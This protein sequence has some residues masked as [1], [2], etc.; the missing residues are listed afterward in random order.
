MKVDGSLK[1]LLQGVSQQPPRDRLPGQST[2]QI[3]MSADPVTG[4]TRRPPTDLV[5]PLSPSSSPR[6]WYDFETATGDKFIAQFDDGLLQVWD[7]NAVAMDVVIETDA[8]PYISDIGPYVC[9]TQE[10]KVIVS[11][12]VRKVAMKSDTRVY[13]N[14]GTGSKPQGLIQI[15]GGNYGRKYAISVDGTEVCSYTCPDGSSGNHSLYVT[16]KVIA[17]I[18]E[19]LLVNDSAGTKPAHFP[20]GPFYS[21]AGALNS[22]TDWTVSRKDDIIRIQKLTGAAFLLTVTDDAGNVTAKAMTET[23]P[24]VS[25][26]PRMAPQGYLARIATETD[27]EEDL[28]VEFVVEDQAGAVAT[29][30]GFGKPGFWQECVASGIKYKLDPA[31]MPHILEYDPNTQVFTFRQGTW[32]DRKVGTTT[33]NPD[34]SFVGYPINDVSTFMNRTVFLAGSNVI[35]SRTN[36]DDDFWM[37]SVSA[38]VDSD[39]IDISSNAV[40]TSEMI[41]AIPHNKDLVIFARKGQFTIFGRTQLTPANAAVVLTTAFE[42]SLDA[43]PAPAGRNVFF[44]VTYGRFAGIREFY[45]EGGTDINDTRPV[46]QHLKKFIRG[47]VTKLSTAS[48]YDLLFVTTDVDSHILYVYQYIW[49]DTE[50]VQSAWSYWEFQHPV[51]YTFFDGD[52]VYVILQDGGE[53]YMTRMP[54]DVQDSEGMSFPAY[55]DARFDVFGCDTQFRLPSDWQRDEDLLIVQ[56]TD[57]PNPGMSARI[58]SIEY[59]V[60]EAGYIVTLKQSMHGGDIIVGT[61]MRS[62]YKPTLP[63]IKDEDGVT[64]GTAKLTVKSFL[65][66]IEDTGDING[67]ML[68]KWGN[69]E[70]VKFQGRVL[71]EEGN[72]VGEPALYTGPFVL[73]F[74]EKAERAE[75]EL[76]TDSFYPMT[77]LDIEWVGQYNKR[78]RRVKSGA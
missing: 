24:D 66:S 44:P 27:P 14:K 16:T 71:G 28:F 6:N 5:G 74:R 46:T 53:C 52:I 75:I 56:S 39:P 34:P 36:K 31:T 19:W 1:S 3:N 67:Q 32:K 23:V 42:A 54:L 35:M 2:A 40:Q 57:C 72:T 7:I 55:M 77:L 78:G 18:L 15:L 62:S 21:G 50:K 8:L 10:N 43:R 9:T 49:S 70:V 69:G 26:L 63:S 12:T 73:P 47:T 60:I 58:E 76:F 11:N 13:A 65:I 30:A 17:E 37:G 59:D 4:L 64:I 38:V 20:I 45:T 41:Y 22:G 33:S 29:N 48:N 68:T 25:D 61:R 51:Q